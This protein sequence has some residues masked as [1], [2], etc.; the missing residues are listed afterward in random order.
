MG[1]GW[2]TR[3]RRDGGHD[4]VVIRLGAA[5]VPR[6]VELDTSHFVYNASS[7]CEVWYACQTASGVELAWQPLLPRVALQP[8]TRHRFW[9]RRP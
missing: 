2:E 4:S 6:L 8:D 7:H 3:R 9:C 1:E 5:G